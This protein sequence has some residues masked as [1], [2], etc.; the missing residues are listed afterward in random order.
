MEKI[1]ANRGV[2]TTPGMDE[3]LEKLWPEGLSAQKLGKRL[4]Q[5]FKVCVS[6]GAV[7]NAARRLGLLIYYSRAEVEECNEDHEPE[8]DGCKW[9][10]GYNHEEKRHYCDAKVPEG[11]K[12]CPT[13]ERFETVLASCLPM[14]NLTIPSSS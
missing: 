13:H 3:E 2:F 10:M 8:P 14:D 1:R 4:A 12:Y 9:F 7:I 5:K 6:K 11:K